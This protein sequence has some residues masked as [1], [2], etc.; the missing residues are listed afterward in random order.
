ME[1]KDEVKYFMGDYSNTWKMKTTALEVDDQEVS[2]AYNK[3]GK[4]EGQKGLVTA[5]SYEAGSLHALGPSI[6]I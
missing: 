2:D 3:N 5:R 4:E 6:L 1:K